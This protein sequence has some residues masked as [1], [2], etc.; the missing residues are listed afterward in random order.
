MS[1]SFRKTV[2]V[3]G[4]L[5]FTKKVRSKLSRRFRRKAKTRL[6]RALASE[7][8]DFKT[9]LPEKRFEIGRIPDHSKFI[10]W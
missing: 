7:A 2:V 6:V 5:G 3:G 4:D 10:A 9:L 8:T 1:R